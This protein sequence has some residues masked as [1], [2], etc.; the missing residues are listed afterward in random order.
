MAKRNAEVCD[1]ID[2]EIMV[3]TWFKENATLHKVKGKT[4]HTVD[5]CD[6]S[7]CGSMI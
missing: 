3:H 1:D 2:A 4:S 6:H 7:C 5:R